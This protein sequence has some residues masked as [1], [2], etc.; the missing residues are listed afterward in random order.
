MEHVVAYVHDLSAVPEQYQEQV[1][2][3]SA[4]PRFPACTVFAV[5]AF[6]DDATLLHKNF[7]PIETGAQVAAWLAAVTHQR[8][9]GS[10]TLYSGSAPFLDRALL[11]QVCHDTSELVFF[12]YMLE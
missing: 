9:S 3:I 12:T 5:Q 1:R 7:F 2:I 11:D 4:A 8:D 6:I 10:V